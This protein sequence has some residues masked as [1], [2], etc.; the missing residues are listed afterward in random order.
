[1]SCLCAM[2]WT[3]GRSV[4]RQFDQDNVGRRVGQDQ[5]E[6]ILMTLAGILLR[7]YPF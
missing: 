2:T 4:G 3:G 1:M 7:S 5:R 6:A